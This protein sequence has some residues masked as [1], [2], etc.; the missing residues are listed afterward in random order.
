[1]TRAARAEA[2]FAMPVVIGVTMVMMLLVAISVTLATRSSTDARAD[3]NTKLAR[4]A[5]DAGLELA[6]FRTNQALAGNSTSQ[7]CFDKNAATGTFSYGGYAPGGGWCTP[8]T[9]SHPD[10]TQSSYRISEE[11]LVPGSSPP[12]YTR[13]VVSSGTVRGET[14]RVYAEISA[15]QGV[16]GFGIYGI[17]AKEKIFFQNSAAAGSPTHPVDVRTNGDIEMKENS[18][19]CGN[20]TAGPGKTLTQTHPATICPGKST[21]PATTLLQFPNYD[22]EH[23]AAKAAN[24]NSRLGCGG[25]ANKDACTSSG[26]VHWSTTSRQLMVENNASLTLGGN[27][28]ALCR[29]H[30]KNNSKLFIAARAPDAPPLRIYI[31]SPANCPGVPSEQFMIENGTG[32]TNLNTDPVTLQ[33]FVRGNTI[34]DYKNNSNVGAATPMMLY[35]PNAT[36]MLQNHARITGGLV[37]KTVELKNNVQFNYDPNAATPVGS[38][39]LIYQPTQQRECTVTPA[40]AAPDA[41]C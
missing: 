18:Y 11:V 32:I 20:V 36:V 41:G 37:G 15:R 7:P 40:G 31:D 16:T 33:I 28:Y 24:D 4:Q 2:G 27:T 22:V 29:L 9:D 34:V 30:L 6:L 3:R 35:A 21:A 17:S 12:Q 23:D 8:V 38:A 13:K 25:G 14:R 1:M 5:A 19:I 26:N 10:G 39:A